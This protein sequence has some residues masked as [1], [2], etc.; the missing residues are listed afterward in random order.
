MN[1]IATTAGNTNSA[2]VNGVESTAT[3]VEGTRN[4]VDV[5]GD[6]STASATGGDDNT[7]TVNGNR[8]SATSSDGNLNTVTVDGEDAKASVSEGSFSTAKALGDSKRG[9]HHRGFEQRHRTG[10]RQYGHGERI[11]QR[12]L[13][14]RQRQQC[15][16][17]RRS[18]QLRQC[19][20]Q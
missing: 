15:N 17:D 16:G 11:S 18:F 4:T 10:L 9:D 13:G 5:T 19:H 3:A 8:S 6:Y 2:K 1:A 7:V 14:R 12:R 20:W